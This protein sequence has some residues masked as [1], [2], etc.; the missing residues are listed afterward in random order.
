MHIYTYIHAYI[1]RC[2][3][4]F[5][6]PLCFNGFRTGLLAFLGK[7]DASQSTKDMIAVLTLIFSTSV[8]KNLN[9]KP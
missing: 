4:V 3:I 6:Y 9:P 7:Q 2:S 8:G 5:G 1:Y